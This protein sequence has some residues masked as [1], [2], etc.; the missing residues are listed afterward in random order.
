MQD[1][2]NALSERVQQ[3]RWLIAGVVIVSLLVGFNAVGGAERARLSAGTYNYTSS[4]SQSVV[5]YVDSESWSKVTT[6]TDGQT[7]VMIYL[8]RTVYF[9]DERYR[10]I[11]VDKS[12]ELAGLVPE[13]PILDPIFLG[14]LQE[15]TLELQEGVELEVVGYLPTEDGA[16]PVPSDLTMTF[17]DDRVEGGSTRFVIDAY[18]PTVAL[19]PQEL[20]DGFLTRDFDV[21]DIASLPTPSEHLS[22]LTASP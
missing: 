15:G 12:G 3:R 4:D 7:D 17:P 22:D 8:N 1:L 20:L 21:I 13:H 10:Q 11:H 9:V 14:R 6:F 19:T 2:R 5:S 16:V 18:S